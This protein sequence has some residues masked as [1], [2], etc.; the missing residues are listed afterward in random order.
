MKVC[1][2]IDNYPFELLSKGDLE[3]S[4]ST[5]YSCDLLS[6]VMAK[7]K[8]DTAWV[9]VQTHNNILA[10]ASLLDF[11]C[12]IIPEGIKVET[13]IIEKAN[14]QDITILSTNLETFEIFKIMYEAGVR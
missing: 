6:W 11:S 1:E 7:G 8:N 4:I 5:V 2:L 13:E 10:V 12:V 3:R 14:E 9:T